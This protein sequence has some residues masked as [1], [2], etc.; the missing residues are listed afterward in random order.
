MW[1][2]EVLAQFVV[3]PINPVVGTRKGKKIKI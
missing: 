3:S 1:N 2:K